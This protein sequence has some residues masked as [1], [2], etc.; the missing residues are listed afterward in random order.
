MKILILAIFL[1]AGCNTEPKMPTDTLPVS[2]TTNWD[3]KLRDNLKIVCIEGHA[4][5]YANVAYFCTEG[6]DRASVLAAKLT[7]EGKPVKCGP[8]LEKEVKN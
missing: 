8:E 2:K 4:Y 7:D 1:A 3:D 6:C 5:Y